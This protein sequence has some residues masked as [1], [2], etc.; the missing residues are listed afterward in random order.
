MQENKQLLSGNLEL[1]I[2]LMCMILDYGREAEYLEGA[3]AHSE[4]VHSKTLSGNQ[5]LENVKQS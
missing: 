1:P 2:S 5:T 3:H 4:N